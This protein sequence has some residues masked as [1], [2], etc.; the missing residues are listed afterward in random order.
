MFPPLN[1]NIPASGLGGHW[2]DREATPGHGGPRLQLRGAELI[3]LNVKTL[4][5]VRK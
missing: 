5:F 2:E 3:L 4:S 1:L